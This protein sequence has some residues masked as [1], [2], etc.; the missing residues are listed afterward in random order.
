MKVK[1]IMT[2]KVFTLKPEDS[3]ADAIKLFRR[4]KITGA[5]VLDNGKLVGIIT[6]KDILTSFALPESP[7]PVSPPPFDFIEAMLEMKMSEWDLERAL[8]RIKEG[9]VEDVMT[10]DVITIDP[11]ADVSDAVNLMTEHNIN[12]I[13]VLKNGKLVGIVTRQDLLKAL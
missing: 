1:E 5:P 11:D 9:R 8:E 6:E 2:K 13:P 10:K 3:L 12:R 4:K 7:S